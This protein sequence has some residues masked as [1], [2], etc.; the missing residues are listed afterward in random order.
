MIVTGDVR[1]DLAAR[2]VEVAGVPVEL[3][4]KEFDIVRALVE[5]LGSAVRRELLM[6]RI[7]G[8]ARMAVSRTLDVHISTLRAKLGRPDLIKT[9]RG[10]GYRLA[11]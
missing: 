9:L 6:D 2:Q 1:V 4:Q 3:A 5:R 11:Q 7:W 8:D 10:F